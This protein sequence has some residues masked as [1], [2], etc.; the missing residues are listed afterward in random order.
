[1]R[2]E[3]MMV[4]MKKRLVMMMATNSPLQRPITTSRLALRTKNRG[5][6]DIRIAKNPQKKNPRSF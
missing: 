5:G 6:G 3:I 2:E 4:L 1:M